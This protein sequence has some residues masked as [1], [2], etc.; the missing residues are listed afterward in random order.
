MKDGITNLKLSATLAMIFNPKLETIEL[1]EPNN[2]PISSKIL[3][4]TILSDIITFIETQFGNA[5]QSYAVL[6]KGLVTIAI[7]M[8]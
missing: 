2:P 3:G 4:K 8:E 6:S 7:P 5:I 1:S